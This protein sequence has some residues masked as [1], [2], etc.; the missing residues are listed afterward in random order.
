MKIKRRNY[1][2][3]ARNATRLSIAVASATARAVRRTPS[4]IPALRSLNNIIRG[5]SER[6]IGDRAPILIY[7]LQRSGTN[8]LHKIVSSQLHVVIKNSDA[9]RSHPRQK[10]FRI[11]DDK[12]RISATGYHNNKTYR[13]FNEFEAEFSSAPIAYLVISKDPYSWILSYKKWA[14][15]CGWPE[16]SADP[17]DDYVSFYG[18]WLQF[19]AQTDK[20]FFVRYVDLLRDP[21][22]AL[23][24]FAKRVE[25]TTGK[26]PTKSLRRPVKVPQSP[27]YSLA[28]D[29]V[30]LDKQYLLAYS[31]EDMISINA[32]LDHSVM[33]GLGY[34]IEPPRH[35]GK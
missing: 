33:D 16:F 28:S 14:K 9:D 12:S 15:K 23:L 3:A 27:A 26:S 4:T 35:A 32:K 5:I 1:G 31:T 24:P 11:F 19:A 34:D 13:D 7:G 17:I 20:I 2:S 8:F 25:A 22:A 10:H 30:H 6:F 21:T 29:T 18:K